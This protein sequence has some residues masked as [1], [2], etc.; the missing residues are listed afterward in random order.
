M[1]MKRFSMLLAFM[2]TL[3]LVVAGCSSGNKETGSEAS[4]GS[5]GE[6]EQE[7][8]KLK[9]AHE[10]PETS[11]IHK[12]VV[13]FTENVTELTDGRVQFEIYP[14]QQLGNASDYLALTRDGVADMANVYPAYFPSEMPNLAN[15]SGLP[16][17]YPSNDIGTKAY[18]D[19][20]SDGTVLE[21]D[22]ISNGI[23]PIAPTAG[24]TFE[25][26]SNGAEIRTPE[27]MKGLKIRS[28]GGVVSELMEYLGAVPVQMP[29]GDAYSGLDQGVIDA[30]NT[31]FEGTRIA[32][33]EELLTFSTKN[34]TLGANMAVFSINEEL[35]QSFPKDIQDAFIQ[36]GQEGALHYAKILAEGEVGILQGFEEDESI[37]VFEPTGDAKAQWDKVYDEFIESNLDEEYKEAYQLFKDAVEKHSN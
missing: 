29:I 31:G 27:D 25:I 23:R 28:S 36:A 9:F 37:T 3:F 8:Y 24:N 22:F 33:I 10:S 21:T 18:W 2:L 26:F 35:Y 19:F 32:G 16:G 4:N 7:T 14:A 20:V 11:T 13:A 1:S 12:A 5:S 30:V 34:V 15:I 17:L 6:N